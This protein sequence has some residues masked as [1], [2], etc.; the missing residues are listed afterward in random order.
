M[1]H[2]GV[3]LFAAGAPYWLP[4]FPTRS[5][6]AA[7]ISLLFVRILRGSFTALSQ[8][9]P[10]RRCL[11]PEPNTRLRESRCQI[12]FTNAHVKHQVYRHAFARSFEFL[13]PVFN[14]CDNVGP[15][16]CECTT[17]SNGPDLLLSKLS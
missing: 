11:F 5:F 1:P 7:S 16:H 10:K 12:W 2:I 14:S 3:R 4:F 15:H 6:P 17:D 8:C 13:L 9:L